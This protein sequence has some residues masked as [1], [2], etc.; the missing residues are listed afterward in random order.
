MVLIY[1]NI[2]C[3]KCETTKDLAQ[4]NEIEFEYKYLSEI[5]ATEKFNVMQAAKK[6]KQLNLPIIFINEEI[7]SF[8]DFNKKINDGGII[9]K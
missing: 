6:V 3:S 7:T 5:P 2:G 9:C 8:E 4:E 1:G